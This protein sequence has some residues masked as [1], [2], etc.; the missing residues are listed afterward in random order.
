[1]L[2]F[3][4][5]EAGVYASIIM[6]LILATYVSLYVHSLHSMS[7]QQHYIAES[8]RIESL[9]RAEN[10]LLKYVG[11][12]NAIY[13]TSTIST[14]I[15]S[16]VIYDS[17][18]VVYSSLVDIKLPPSSQVKII[19]GGLAKLVAGG[20]YVLGVITENGNLVTWTPQQETLNELSAVLLPAVRYQ[21]FVNGRPRYVSLAT[22]ISLSELVCDV[23]LNTECVGALNTTFLN[24]RKVIVNAP[25]L[26][27]D[28]VSL[29]M[30]VKEPVN[31]TLKI[32]FAENNF[33]TPAN[34]TFY[35]LVLPPN[36]RVED[37]ITYRYHVNHT[38][39]ATQ[40]L[41]KVVVS[42]YFR[43][44]VVV[45]VVSFLVNEAITRAG[46]GAL[47][48]LAFTVSLP[49]GQYP[50]NPTILLDVEVIEVR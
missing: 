8:Q 50:P 49:S 31:I 16:L 24:E 5:G 7:Q 47:I 22:N 46:A 25:A 48:T 38:T 37:V 3:R 9:R 13:A 43:K 44:S 29:Y 18:G 6:T 32:I 10:I 40:P 41:K 2:K 14:S 33:I 30:W 17:A 42:E 4:L 45:D 19:E 21:S 27:A 36:S 28:L 1:M 23:E 39:R 15:K 12:E 26:Y 34:I 20:G 35:Y 11:G